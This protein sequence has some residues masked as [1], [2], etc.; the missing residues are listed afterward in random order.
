MNLKKNIKNTQWV[1]TWE[2]IVDYIPINEIQWNILPGSTRI[3]QSEWKW[4]P[5]KSYDSEW[6]PIIKY[7]SPSLYYTNKN[8]EE[9]GILMF[10]ERV[11][12]RVNH[13]KMTAVVRMSYFNQKWEEITFDTSKDFYIDY[14][15]SYIGYNYYVL[16]G[17]AVIFLLW[18][19]WFIIAWKRS[20]RCEECDEKITDDMIVCPHCSHILKPKEYKAMLKKWQIHK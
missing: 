16:L 6:N 8:I 15:E 2:E 19:F 17:M 18:F 14:R 20:K 11:L 13:K 9:N 1:I 10:W 12:E 3:F 7:W 4:F 5:Y